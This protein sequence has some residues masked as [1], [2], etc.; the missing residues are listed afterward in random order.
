[1]NI[2]GL[3]EEA[4]AKE[5]SRR[6]GKGR[7]HAR[8]TLRHLYSSGALQGLGEREDFRG[9]RNLAEGI[10]RDFTAPMPEAAATEEEEG[11][12][13]FS[14]SLSQGAEVEAVIVPMRGHQSLC[15][16]TQ[17]GCARGCA[18]CRTGR[19]GLIRNLGAEEILAQYMTARFRFGAD[20]RNVVF[21]GMGEPFDNPEGLYGALEILLEPRGPGLLPGRIT[22]S[23]CGHAE[24]LEDLGRRIRREPG[25]ALRLVTLAVSLH[26]ATDEK[27]SSLMPVNRVWPLPRL[28]EA[29]LQL[30]QAG[31]KDRL[32]LEYLVI[33]AVNDSE[34]DADALSRFMEGL[35]AKVNLIP[36]RPPEGSSLP[37]STAKGLEGFWKALRDRNVPCFTRKEKGEG[38]GASCGQLAS[39]ERGREVF[40][41]PKSL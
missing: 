5:F 11:T 16:S 2:L 22:I 4:L 15:L 12:V 25:T 38:I 41:N 21:M 34:S 8:E 35:T 6:Y 26:A 36:F 40:H 10:L 39:R 28:K 9:A 31:V 27:R 3:S 13:K 37:P 24:G 14:L 29:L 20:I 19:M 18:F 32:Y 7:Y 17:A 23:T 1:M 33:P 30:P